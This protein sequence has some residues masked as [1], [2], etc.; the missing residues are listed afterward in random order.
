MRHL[1]ILDFFNLPFSKQKNIRLLR[2]GILFFY[3]VNNVQL[4]FMLDISYGTGR[5]SPPL[6]QDGISN[7]ALN[8]LDQGGVAMAICMMIMLMLCL[9]GAL[10]TS[11]KRIFTF[12]AFFAAANLTNS[13]YL[14]N[15]GGHHLMLLVLFYLC[16]VNEKKV[17]KGSWSNAINKG[18]LLAIQIQI[19]LVYLVSALYKILGDVWLEGTAMWHSLMLKEYSLPIIYN[20]MPEA[21]L[22]LMIMTYFAIAYQF[23]F[24]ILIWIPATRR[25]I[26][27]LGI[28]MHLMIAFVFGLFNFGAAMIICYFSFYM[29]NLK[30]LVGDRTMRR[31]K[32]S[33]S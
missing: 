24:A 13:T 30:Y 21:N 2:W 17:E 32:V 27:I 31:T 23:L 1:H 19:C 5:I 25:W 10:L 15:S 22:I 26:L 6:G 3:L 16:F 12:I 9:F 18:A 33:P 14:L 20:N 11:Y 4:C 8:L 7:Y 28:L 29:P